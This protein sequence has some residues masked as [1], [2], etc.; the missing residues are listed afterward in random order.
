M[1]VN[2]AKFDNKCPAKYFVGA[3]SRHQGIKEGEN[4]VFTTDGEM[5]EQQSKK[6]NYK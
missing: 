3:R 5:T 2:T 6:E 1:F 4:D